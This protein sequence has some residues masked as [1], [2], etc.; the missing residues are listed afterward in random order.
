MGKSNVAE[1]PTA[2]S[3]TASRI[4]RSSQDAAK[5]YQ[6]KTKKELLALSTSG[7]KWEEWTM[8][9]VR[10]ELYA[11]GFI[12]EATGTGPTLPILSLV[13]LRIAASLPTNAVVAADALRA[14]AIG[15]DIKRLDHTIEKMSE[16]L[17]EVLELVRELDHDRNEEEG[18]VLA[19]QDAA[20]LLTRTVEEQAGDI[21]EITTRLDDEVKG[22]TQRAQETTTQP[23]RTFEDHPSMQGSAAEGA[24]LYATVAAQVH[25][26]AR[27]AAIANATAKTRQ[28]LIDKAPGVEAWSAGLT[29]KDLREKA[30][31]A[32]VLMAQDGEGEA[33]PPDA[34]FFGAGVQRNGAVML[35]MNT[36]AAANWLKANMDRFLAAMGGT[37][38]YKERLYNVMV[39]YVLVSFD[40]AL[41]GALHVVEN[42]NNLPTGTLLKARWVKP[43]WLRREGQRVAHAVFGFNDAVAANRVIRDG[44]WVD[45]SRVYGQ[46]LLTE[47]V[48]C[49][50]CQEIGRGHVAASCTYVHDVCARC[51][52]MHRTTTCSVADNQR[53]C[54]NCRN[55]K[56][57]YHGHGA[58]DRSC[59]IFEEKLQFALERNVEAKHPY[60]LVESDPNSWVTHEEIE[61]TANMGTAASWA[62]QGPPQSSKGPGPSAHIASK[63][64]GQMTRGDTG[65]AKQAQHLTG[66][67]AGEWGSQRSTLH[68][69]WQ[70]PNA[71]QNRTQARESQ[72]GPRTVSDTRM[73]PERAAMLA[74]EEEITPH[75]PV[76]DRIRAQIEKDR[77]TGRMLAQLGAGDWS[78]DIEEGRGN[79]ARE[80]A[81][82]PSIEEDEEEREIENTVAPRMQTSP[83]RVDE[84]NA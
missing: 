23:T 43:V 67:A 30:R 52:G 32:T 75:R 53:A 49:M 68:S 72:I 48:R 46:K 40:P 58:A 45:G 8:T 69:Y 70:A 17:G 80:P 27:A 57:E 15:M 41:D 21:A 25:P 22:I 26:P 34:Q 4:T 28:I 39:R 74:Q 38:I 82:L 51:G 37:S 71:T 78:A 19:L 3:S 84:H 65:I 50:K 12:E 13:I 18:R 83:D 35:H 5:I 77:A 66:G 11:K 59:P 73:N 16:E 44:A 63:I 29:E 76:R 7:N 36:T 10:G 64:R 2:T 24:R 6:G 1:S 31:M 20:A 54:S 62:R 14:V 42:D 81:V 9:A 47:P 61:A 60:F 79:V 56:R 55:A 33:P